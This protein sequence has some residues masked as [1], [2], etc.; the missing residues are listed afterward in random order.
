[1]SENVENQISSDNKTEGPTSSSGVRM[2][3]LTTYTADKELIK[4]WQEMRMDG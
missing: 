3:R 2:Y 1:M 4:E